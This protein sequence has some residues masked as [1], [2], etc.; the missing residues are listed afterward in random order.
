MSSK[1]K[2]TW[3]RALCMGNNDIAHNEFVLV[4]L[5]DEIFKERYKEILNGWKS[6]EEYTGL[7]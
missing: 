4:V 1:K 3:I 5:E 6:D 7:I 2:P